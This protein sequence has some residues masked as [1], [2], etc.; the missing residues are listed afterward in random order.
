VRDAWSVYCDGSITPKVDMR[1]FAEG[2]LAGREMALMKHPHRDCVY[3]EIEACVER[4]KI[5]RAEG[6][7]VRGQLQLAGM[8][9]NWGLWACGVIVRRTE[10]PMTAEIGHCMMPF[11]REVPRDQL[12]FPFV[13]RQLGVRD[14]ITTIDADVFNNDWFTFTPHKR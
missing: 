10:S 14:R 8:P 4:K 6:E 9:R 3:D 5:T 2:A 7:K 11:V 13:V 1:A 12:W